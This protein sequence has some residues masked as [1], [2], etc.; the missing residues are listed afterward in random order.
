MESVAEPRVYRPSFLGIA[1][2][3]VGSVAFFVVGLSMV[4]IGAQRYGGVS[5]VVVGA[6]ALSFSVVL[7][8]VLATNRLIVTS[9]G[10]VYWNNLRR[11]TIGWPEVR[12][13]GVGRGRSATRWPALVFRLNDGSATVTNVTSFTTKYP[14]RVADEIGALQRQHAPLPAPH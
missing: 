11:R 6:L 8:A 9:A 5:S 1:P 14:A 4:T 10:L 3:W 2:A 13:F 7:A 12:S